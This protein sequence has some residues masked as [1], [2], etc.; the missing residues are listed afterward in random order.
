MD[1]VAN[2]L[3]GDG[4]LVTATSVHQIVVCARTRVKSAKI[5]IQY[6]SA[7]DRLPRK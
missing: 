1:V 2:S 6:G 5:N 7:T 3:R 4:E